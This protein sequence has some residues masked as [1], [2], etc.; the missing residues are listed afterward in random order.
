M[1]S[2]EQQLSA[3]RTFR[4]FASNMLPLDEAAETCADDDRANRAVWT[5]VMQSLA[6]GARLSAVMAETKLWPDMT[7]R[8]LAAAEQTQK[9]DPVFGVLVTIT[10]N[11]RKVAAMLKKELIAPA[12]YLFLSVS[13]MFTSTLVVFPLMSGSIKKREGLIAALDGVHATMQVAL[14]PVI[15]VLA[16][17]TAWL[18]YALQTSSGKNTLL[19]VLDRFPA[20]GRGFRGVSL[21]YWCSL[22]QLLHSAGDIHD[23]D[24]IR[25]AT[26]SLPE[27]HAEAFIVLQQ[28]IAREGTL[29]RAVDRDNW[30]PDDPR[31][32]WPALFRVALKSAASTGNLGD[33]VGPLSQDLLNAG[34][35]DLEKAIKRLALI[36]TLMTVLGVGSIMGIYSMTQ[37]AQVLAVY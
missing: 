13:L 34:L 36:G 25:M 15:G 21:S 29:Q 3:Y 28:D 4:G 32:Q 6:R 11:R 37:L 35:T 31:R 18:I 24:A 2:L 5:N 8:A 7:V 30:R 1:Q 20:W 17:A 9:L 22:V 19:R 12:L 27:V 33:A 26:E 16:A 10:E 23:D 14:W